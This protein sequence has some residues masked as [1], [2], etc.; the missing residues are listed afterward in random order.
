[1]MRADRRWTVE[2]SQCGV[3]TPPRGSSSSSGEGPLLLRSRTVPFRLPRG[4]STT[5]RS[6]VA[7]ELFVLLVLAG[8]LSVG[9]GF[10]L[11]P[12]SLHWTKPTNQNPKPGRHTSS[13]TSTARGL[14]PFRDAD[15]VEQL[16]G[17]VRYSLVPL[18]PDMHSTTLFVGGIEEFAT[19]DDLSRLMGGNPAC[20]VRKPNLTSL[21]YG[22]VAFRTVAEAE[23]R[24]RHYT[25]GRQSRRWAHPSLILHFLNLHSLH[26]LYCLSLA[27]RRPHCC[28]PVDWNGG[29]ANSTFNQ[30]AAIWRWCAFLK[31]S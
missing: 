20:V 25:A 16:V 26:S 2:G 14:L 24:A 4:G 1:M 13:C 19:D 29:A 21:R 15:L 28:A 18:P 17:G 27:P 3:Q 5:R 23:V 11:Q 7:A 31:N 9:H 12:P 10:G 22:F 6:F 8:N 30:F